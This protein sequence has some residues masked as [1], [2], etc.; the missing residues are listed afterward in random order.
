MGRW[1]RPDE[2][3]WAATYLASDEASFVTGQTIAVNGGKTVW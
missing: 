1:G 2:V 3:G